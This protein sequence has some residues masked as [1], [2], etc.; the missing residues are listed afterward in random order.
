VLLVIVIVGD[1]EE[2]LFW[3]GRTREG[4]ERGKSTWARLVGEGDWGAGGDVGHSER[5]IAQIR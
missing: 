3:S 4:F 1:V 2:R 5:E